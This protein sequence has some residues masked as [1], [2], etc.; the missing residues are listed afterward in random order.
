[1]IFPDHKVIFFHPGKTAVTALEVA[2]G[3][4]NKTH[5]PAICNRE[6]FKGWDKEH[7]LYLQHAPAKFM[8]DQLPEEIW[9]EYFKFVTVR[10]PFDR[11]VSAY[12]FN[13]NFFSRA[14]GDFEQFILS[15]ADILEQ[16]P[17]PS[18]RHYLPLTDYSF[19][20]DTKVVDFVVRFEHIQQ[21][22]GALGKRLGIELCLERYN[23]ATGQDRPFVPASELYSRDMIRSMREVYAR[24][25]EAFGYSLEPPDRFLHPFHQAKTTQGS[26]PAA[27]WVKPSVTL[28]CG[29]GC[30]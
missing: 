8:R 5:D 10:N 24:D 12:H 25:F 15:L 20:D 2:F 16:E 26:N 19:V 14:F 17:Y 6:V 7:D 3:Y 21:D 9:E 23:T 18:S 1:M 30:D 11:L 22:V 13:Y 29:E 4:S 27:G 28:A